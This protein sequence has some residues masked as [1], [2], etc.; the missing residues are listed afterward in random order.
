MNRTNLEI[1]ADYLESE[2]LKAGFSM[3][4]YSEAGAEYK[5]VCGSV[6]CAIGHGPHAGIP[7][8]A[9]ESWD[10]YETRVF[11]LELDVW[12]WCF[13]SRWTQ[14]DDTPQGAAKR[15]RYLLEHGAPPDDFLDC[16]P[17]DRY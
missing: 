3:E 9:S 14:I 2:N 1:L 4:K 7:K 5:P 6:G 17:W 13:S 15:I 8:N 10:A 16:P 12:R 11:G